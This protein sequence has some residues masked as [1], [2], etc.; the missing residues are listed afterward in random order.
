MSQFVNKLLKNLKT[1]RN[2]INVRKRLLTMLRRSLKPEIAARIK[3]INK[4]IK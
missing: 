3:N 2:K 4:E 1:I